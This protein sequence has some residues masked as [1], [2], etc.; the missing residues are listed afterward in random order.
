MQKNALNKIK[1]M[2]QLLFVL[3]SQLMGGKEIK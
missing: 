3:T 2:L 1:A